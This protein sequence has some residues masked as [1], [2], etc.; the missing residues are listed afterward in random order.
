MQHQRSWVESPLQFIDDT[1]GRHRK[2]PGDSNIAAFLPF[3]SFLIID[4]VDAER[5]VENL[6]AIRSDSQRYLTPVFLLRSESAEAACLGDGVVLDA[7]AASERAAVIERRVALLA[8]LGP[9]FDATDR[10]LRFLFTRAGFELRP[11]RDW[12]VARSYRYP[13]LDALREVDTDCRTWLEA[14][15]S[16]KLIEPAGTIVDRVRHCR[17]CD[18]SHLNY[19]DLCPTCT[20]LQIKAASFLHCFGCGYVAEEGAFQASAQRA[21]PKCA[22]I[23]RHIGVDYDRALET[24]SCSDCGA[25]FSDAKIVARCLNC[26]REFDPVSLTARDVRGWR[27]SRAGTLAVR[28]GAAVPQVDGS[29]ASIVSERQFI[30][31]V[32]WYQRTR[33]R[34]ATSQFGLICVRVG[35]GDAMA[36]AA[37]DTE[38]KHALW[39]RVRAVVRGSEVVGEGSSDSLWVFCPNSDPSSLENIRRRLDALTDAIDATVTGPAKLRVSFVH[40][41]DL[42]AGVHP[43]G[44]LAQIARSLAVGEVT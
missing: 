41:D 13:L 17:A 12:K 22:R 29:L 31:L 3:E 2:K 20:G 5:Q 11:I 10:L 30:D 37:C 33:Q 14:L 15:G 36:A 40:S 23:L 32:A 21:C 18:S 8:E 25:S 16:A 44:L 7:G 38:L 19:I 39:Q 43:E 35:E 9:P 24:F 1:I 27:L 34:D 28:A 42:P 26:S 6:H 4:E